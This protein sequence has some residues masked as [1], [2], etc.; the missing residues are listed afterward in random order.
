MKG[1]SIFYLQH[2]LLQEISD[3]GIDVNTA[4]VYD[5]EDLESETFGVIRSK[6]AKVIC[7]RDKKLGAAYV[8][9]IHGEDFVGPANVMFSY[10]WGSNI[11]EIATTLLVQCTIEN[12]DPKRTY[13]WMIS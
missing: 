1:V 6:G 7:P 10:T 2:V 11:L 8:D 4:T 5:L 12:R 13:V 9:C 3:S